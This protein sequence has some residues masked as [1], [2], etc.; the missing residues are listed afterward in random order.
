MPRGRSSS[1]Y[2]DFVFGCVYAM[3]IHDAIRLLIAVSCCTALVATLPF[4]GPAVPPFGFTSRGATTYLETERKFLSLPSA[5]RIRNAHLYLA[6]QPHMAG[7]RRDREL[8]EW[9]RD[10]F[11][12]YGLEDVEITTHEVLLPWPEEV[13]VELTAP[14]AWRAAMRE[15]PID[16]DRYT[17]VSA[18]VAGLP[19]H[20]YSA[21]GE[22]TAPVVYAGSGN[23][24]DYDRLAAAGISVRGKIALVRYSVPYSYR[25]F[26]ALTAQQRGAAGILIYSDPADDGYG[27]GKVY[28]EGPW[29]PPTHIQRG[30]IVFDFLVPGDPL[31]PGWPSVPGARRIPASEAISLPKIISAP[32]SYVDAQVILEAMGGPEAPKEWKGALPITYR[33]GGNAT[34]RMRIKQD[35]Q[36]RPIWTVTGRIRGRAEPEREVIVGNHRDAWIYG[37]VDPSSGSAALME[38]ART[39]GELK[40][41]GWRPRR[42][43]VFASWD[44]EEFTLT[45]ST[46]W[47]EQH[48]GR[49]KERAVAYLN[50]DSAASG[51]NFAASA[52][53][54]LNRVIAEAAGIVRDPALRIPIAAAIRD[55]RTRERGSLPTG[56][57]DELVGN[58]LGSGS[59]YTVFLNHLGIPVADLSFDG[60]Y[61]VYHSIY[62]NHNWVAK[63]G[64]PGFRYHVAMVQLWGVLT[65]RLAEA[66]VIPL[67]YAPYASAISGYLLELE[68]RWTNRRNDAFD[69]VHAAVA[70]FRAA[71]ESLNQARETALAANNL[72]QMEMLNRRLIGAE[73][74]L[75]DEAGI[76]GRPWY[77]HQIYAPKQTYAPELLPAV[78]EAIDAA[79]AN[80]QIARQI[81]RLTAAVRRA[82]AA[83]SS[84]ADVIRPSPT[85]FDGGDR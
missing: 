62:D 54:A 60:P 42:S 59:D 77:R 84:S 7:T 65:M 70:E 64:D 32:L 12:R 27:K 47:G 41:E 28:P 8:A 52:V 19:Y 33:M 17:Q 63:I 25:G 79:S 75:L 31:T 18:E 56:T 58:R 45:S 3:F 4:Q 61:G 78:A 16:G 35:D 6:D 24:A 80:D 20:A 81:H 22:V 11:L 83:I 82:A 43:V 30:G 44:A 9:T 29:G 72:Q 66:D 40:K 67:D 85:P 37:G 2:V 21:S 53:P 55:R 50:V 34:V 51:P 73:R 26:K 13:S 68:R 74:A 15:M 69:D 71:A 23:P 57:S 5:E 38:L 76:P 1:T 48:A 10:E 39:L 36:V 49:L 14:R 46:E